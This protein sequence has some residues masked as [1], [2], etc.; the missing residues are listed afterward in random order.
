M[1]QILSLYQVL[2]PRSDSW[3]L[4]YI[5]VLVFRM[6][7]FEL[8]CILYIV[9]VETGIMYRYSFVLIISFVNLCEMTSM[10]C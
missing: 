1:L 5:L 10:A 6:P 7:W 2:V 3:V 8:L 4:V 9:L